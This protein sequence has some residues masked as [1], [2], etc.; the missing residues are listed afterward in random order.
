MLKGINDSVEQAEK[1]GRLLRGIP[2]KINLIPFN[3]SPGIPFKRSSEEQMEAFQQVLRDMN[4]TVMMRKSRGR[5][6][7]AACGQLYAERCEACTPE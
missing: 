1:L 5:D 6:I 4:Y 2:A 7:S 3:E